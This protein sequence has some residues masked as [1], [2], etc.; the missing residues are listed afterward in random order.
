MK[1][2]NNISNQVANARAVQSAYDKDAADQMAEE[3]FRKQLNAQYQREVAAATEKLNASN[4]I[5][6]KLPDNSPIPSFHVVAQKYFIGYHPTYGVVLAA[7]VGGTPVLP[8]RLYNRKDTHTAE[9]ELNDAYNNLSRADYENILK[10]KPSFECLQSAYRMSAYQD[11]L[12]NIIKRM[13]LNTA[14]VVF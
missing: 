7:S 4:K 10:N 12:Q 5:G 9:D 6:Q 13:N 2:D 11:P 8:F 14:A 1:T 3:R